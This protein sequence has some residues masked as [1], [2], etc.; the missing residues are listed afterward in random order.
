LQL[1]IRQD[2]QQDRNAYTEILVISFIMM[3]IKDNYTPAVQLECKIRYQAIYIALHYTGMGID[4]ISDR[5]TRANFA[6]SKNPL[7]YSF[8]IRMY[9]ITATALSS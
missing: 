9:T 7:L 4:L 8:E 6:R 1:I 3:K 2:R 5:E